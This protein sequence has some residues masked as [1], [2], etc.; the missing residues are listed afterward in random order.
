MSYRE[1][2]SRMVAAIAI[3]SYAI[4]TAHKFLYFD[5]FTCYSTRLQKV[6][7]PSNNIFCRSGH[8][9]ITISFLNLLQCRQVRVCQYPTVVSQ[10]FFCIK[11]STRKYDASNNFIENLFCFQIHTKRVAVYV[12][13]TP[14]V[15]NVEMSAPIRNPKLFWAAFCLIVQSI[16]RLVY[17]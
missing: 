5:S 13:Q 1:L 10:N 7:C 12:Q 8:G 3:E 9:L 6:K 16:I 11:Q 4:K 15:V 17:W 2:V 14:D